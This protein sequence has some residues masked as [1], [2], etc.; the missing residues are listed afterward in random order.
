VL[1]RERE[2]AA[3]T[4]RE[5]WIWQSD[6]QEERHLGDD[7]L[8]GRLS[9]SILSLTFPASLG[10]L[11]DVVTLPR[12]AP[13]TP[14]SHPASAPPYPAFIYD[15]LLIFFR[16][17]LLTASRSYHCPHLFPYRTFHLSSP[18][19]DDCPPCIPW[20]AALSPRN[21][22][23]ASA[24]SR[25]AFMMTPLCLDILLLGEKTTFPAQRASA[26]SEGS[27]LGR[28]LGGSFRRGRL[29]SNTPVRLARSTSCVRVFH[30]LRDG[31]SSSP[32]SHSG[33]LSAT[34]V[35]LCCVQA[36]Y[37]LSC[38][39]PGIVR[40]GFA[41]A[42]HVCCARAACCEYPKHTPTCQSTH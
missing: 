16:F 15:R 4:C 6:T 33:L 10:P 17:S 35:R 34:G 24:C 27:A 29:Q 20:P 36:Y 19:S 21:F 31:C 37:L 11:L 26:S 14:S 28:V 3:S 38:R 40:F 30:T 25:H 32:L 41:S 13:S 2:Q 18:R 39:Q 1:R 9:C 42:P 12:P 23:P 7:W 5:P 8:G 22:T